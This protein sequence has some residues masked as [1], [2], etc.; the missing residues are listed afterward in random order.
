MTVNGQGPGE[1]TD[2]IMGD[3]GWH[4]IGTDGPQIISRTYIYQWIVQCQ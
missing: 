2:T 3:T 4:G 1:I